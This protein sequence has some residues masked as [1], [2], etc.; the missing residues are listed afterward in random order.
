MGHGMRGD[1]ERIDPG[2]MRGFSLS[3]EKSPPGCPSSHR[4]PFEKRSIARRVRGSE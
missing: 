3:K 2:A 4:P 1:L